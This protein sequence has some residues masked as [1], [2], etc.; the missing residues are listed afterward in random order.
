MR[1][2]FVSRIIGGW[3]GVL[4][5]LVLSVG[6]WLILGPLASL[7]RAQGCDETWNGSS[8]TDWNTAAN[9]TPGSVPTG[10]Q[11]VCIPAGSFTVAL[12]GS[13][14]A[15]S[16]TI[17]T[18]DTVAVTA[19]QSSGGT[20]TLNA[21]S[22][23]SG[24]LELTDSATTASS[25]E[26][27]ILIGDGATLTNSGAIVS[28]PGAAGQGTR[29]IDGQNSDST[30]DNAA[31]ATIT[32]N[33]D[34][35]VD[36][37]QAGLFE[38]SGD[39]TI[40]SGE[41]LLVDPN[42]GGV[43][44]SPAT[45]SAEMD[46]DGGT[47]TDSGTFEQGIS[48]A[49]SHSSAA[50]K[51]SGATITGAGLI[52]GSGAPT[53]M[54]GS[55]VGAS[56]SG[57]GSGTYTFVGTSSA[58]ATTL[59]G[60]VGANQ[61][62]VLSASTTNG[63]VP[64]Q[65]NSN[66][67]NDGTLELTDSD[68]G[69]TN[70]NADT[71]TIG[72]GNT[73]TNDGT[74]LSDPGPGGHGQRIITGAGANTGTLLNATDGTITINQDLQIDSG[75]RGVFTT[76][77]NVSIASGEKLLVAPD[78]SFLGGS[79]TPTVNITGGTIT[80][81]GTFDMGI[82]EA[83]S[84]G[85]G[86][87]LNVTG[88]SIAGGVTVDDGGTASFSGAGSG[89]YTFGGTSSAASTT[90]S[91]TIASGQTVVLRAGDGLGGVPV[92]ASSDV[93]NNG[94]I[95]FT[96]PDPPST[97]QQNVHLTMAAPSTLTNNGSMIFDPGG[98][99]QGI[100]TLD[101]NVTNTSSGTIDV[102]QTLQSD[103]AHNVAS[104]VQS[105][106]KISVAGG[107]TWYVNTAG[108]GTVFTLSGGTIT[109][110]GNL[111]VNI[112]PASGA[113][114][115]SGGLV[116][117]GGTATGN[118]LLAGNVG[119]SFA[120]SGS[121]TF[122]LVGQQNLLSGNIGAGCRVV[123]SASSN[124]AGSTTATASASFTNNGTIE[125][126][127]P[128]PVGSSAASAQLVVQSG[129]LGNTGT[130]VSDAGPAGQGTRSIQGA[131]TN[132][133]TV[134]VNKTLAQSGGQFTNQGTVAVA[135]GQGLGIAGSFPQL[136]G[137]TT[138]AAG[139][140]L[141]TPGGVNL[142]GGTLGGAG[143]VAGNLEN[144][145]Q[146]SPS[147]SPATLT[148]NGTYSQSADGFVTA[149]ANPTGADRLSVTGAAS[150]G[151]TLEMSNASGFT[152]P[153]G[154][155][156][157]VLQA[158]SVTGH[159]ATVSGPYSATYDPQDVTVTS[160]HVAGAA[161]S[162]GDVSVDEPAYGTATAAFTVTLSAREAGPVTVDYATANG[163]AT[164]GQDYRATSG[165]LT[166]APGV[167]SKTIPVTVIGGVFGPTATLFV[168]LSNP[169]GA[170]LANSRATGTIVRRPP[171]V[172]GAVDPS[173]GGNGGTVT[174]TIS[175]SGLFGKP[176]VDLAAARQ[177]TIHGTDVTVSADGTSLTA[178]FDLSGATPGARSVVVDDGAASKLIRNGF[179]VVPASSPLISVQ[180][181]GPAA[182]GPNA[183]WTGEL[184]YSNAGNVDAYGTVVQIGGFPEGTDV[185]VTGATG[186]TLVTDLAGSRTI[187]VAIGRIPASS[188][189]S[190]GISFTSPAGR[191]GSY[192]NL[193]AALISTSARSSNVPNPGV[194]MTAVVAKNTADELAGTVT[195]SG[196]LGTREIGVDVTRVP[197][198]SDGEPQIT[199]T[200]PAD[201]ETI[202]A[203]VPVAPLPGDFAGGTSCEVGGT[204]TVSG[205]SRAVA[206][207][208]AG[209]GAGSGF[210]ETRAAGPP[211]ART[212]GASTWLRAVIDG[213][214]RKFGIGDGALQTYSAAQNAANQRAFDNCLVQAGILDPDR[215][216]GL[217]T[218][219]NGQVSLQLASFLGSVAGG[220]AGGIPAS[221]AATAIGSQLRGAWEWVVFKN[222]V[223]S[224][225]PNTGSVL[226]ADPVTGLVPNNANAV[227]A[228]LANI[229]N[230]KAFQDC[231]GKKPPC[232]APNTPST[233][234]SSQGPIIPDF[235]PPPQPP[236]PPP[237]PVQERQSEDPNDMVGP[238]G[239]GAKHWVARTGRSPYTYT[240]TFQN[241]PSASAPAYRVVVSDALSRSHFRLS[242]LRLGPVRV[243]T[244]LIAP[245]PGLQHWSTR[246]DLRPAHGAFVD[247]SGGLNAS[248]GVVTWTFETIDASTG[249]PITD[250]IEGF[251]APDRTPP[252]GDGSVS[253]TV[254]PRSG[255]RTG[256][257]IAN[258]ATIVFDTNK[259]IDTPT[260]V[261]E[262]DLSRPSSRIV[263]VR[264]PR[265]TVR[266]AFRS[267]RHVV[268]RRVHVIRVSWRGS[269]RYSGVAGFAL[270]I[271][272]GRSRFI[273]ATG[274]TRA[275]HAQIVCTT[276]RTYRFYT[277]AY[278]AVGNV[279]RG[280]SR[281]SGAVRCR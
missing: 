232:K 134:T 50:L 21:N 187:S 104:N 265:A 266:L 158:G 132:T 54:A 153:L 191:I 15:G 16:L 251:L 170:S 3:R 48:E 258:R 81:D 275:T 262:V 217:D 205:G 263:S 28:D 146:V 4:I 108:N 166:F 215:L 135:A 224:G 218:A 114:L 221:L 64:M 277:V 245:P 270:Y 26:A 280:H 260:W 242:T 177:P 128:D 78:G 67:T 59:G 248:T 124:G 51:V 264:A 46:I 169:G 164:A 119:A 94:T 252:E 180:I 193:Q 219:A 220:A 20:L 151:G 176:T 75:Q 41:K 244:H 229:A 73:L 163:T 96:D 254:T 6:A 95:E 168:D 268:R 195:M 204:I 250:A 52:A 123:L 182:I 178:T 58:S 43:G 92:T 91:G 142:Q 136:A 13:G 154:Q 207:S 149:Q 179:S 181:A 115:T 109:D 19:T 199:T 126:T 42:G 171:S 17:G 120:G 144:A 82:S 156:Y 246:I 88:G 185:Q 70:Q 7:V 118:P 206:E 212:A 33:Q 160:S 140:T 97:G 74:I 223:D 112:N 68:T 27:R 65:V 63:G 276:G 127:D 47:I 122:T 233:P 125:L 201:D 105:S 155:Q 273:A 8:S 202:T 23:N 103:T 99:R 235:C 162:I 85:G 56:F 236:P 152:P 62:V 38:T 40:A 188:T 237:F 210:A 249:Q 192:A 165:T 57:T 172:S 36:T 137:T 157:K 148:I 100:Y 30:L 44:G 93:T 259:P 190:L 200:G 2:R 141:T 161:L 175:G 196:P 35:Q 216:K 198:P 183:R 110:T 203:V 77:G 253:F 72:S 279:Q 89:T 66:V 139:G 18:G 117:D 116:V 209:C 240:A 271:A 274:V 102:N 159:F 231:Y 239:P 230:N 257:V 12:T 147:P 5:A 29:V 261:N 197:A 186:P 194:T 9:W 167:T 84:H 24:T 22:T 69:G 241:K 53:D 60:T 79:L 133:G 107:Q 80:N 32:V 234:R 1:A 238:A 45:D 211:V 213:W 138:I 113:A 49:G 278:S 243:G 130:I 106:G 228:L 227:A 214:S 61:T 25:Q 173:S 11:N 121:G 87:A 98:G 281:P 174:V 184:I 34:L 272:S 111:D 55:G 14:N 189:G 76:S 10:S 208:L 267:K 145:G 226:P 71:I 90:L 150:L 256:A 129:T 37:G 131:V 143:T 86:P 269:D 255:L 225:G 39:V 222:V 83:G 101:G 247:V 31:G